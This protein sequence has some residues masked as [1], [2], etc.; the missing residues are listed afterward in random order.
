MNNEAQMDLE[1]INIQKNVNDFALIIEEGCEAK[2]DKIIDDI[3][4][5]TLMEIAVVTVNSLNGKSIDEMA[6]TLFNK[7]GIGKKEENNGI[8]LLIAKD[9]NQYRLEVGLGIEEIMDKET[10]KKLTENIIVPNFRKGVYAQAILKLVKKIA[11]KV[12]LS[13]FSNISN[14]SLATGIIAI[15]LTIA[16][17][18][19]TLGAAFMNIPNIGS[20]TLPVFYTLTFLPAIIA[21]VIAAICGIV[22]ISIISAKDI[23]TRK[24]T[25]SITGIILAVIGM[26]S[27]TLILI[28]LQPVLDFLA[29]LFLLS[30]GSY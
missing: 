21:S 26:A 3:E 2:I 17:I 5:K 1:N 10:V 30:S 4:R 29:G 25:R 28:Y 20:L 8:L 24:I 11:G 9:E 23:R 18:L 15:F 27:F 12:S 22:D 14:I 7:F 13:R 16:A 19:I 6:L